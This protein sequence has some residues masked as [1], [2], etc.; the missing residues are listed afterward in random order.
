MLWQAH[1][2]TRDFYPVLIGELAQQRQESRCSKRRRERLAMRFDLGAESLRRFAVKP[3]QRLDH[4]L[5]DRLHCRA[6]QCNALFLAND[7]GSALTR[8]RLV[9]LGGEIE[10]AL[11]LGQ[12]D[13]L[14]R[15]REECRQRRLRRRMLEGGELRA[16]H[17]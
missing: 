1:A 10:R 7:C 4:A 9:A 3:R 13:A 8:E 6:R 15:T 17:R 2:R 14:R 12:I 16:A 11:E 5:L